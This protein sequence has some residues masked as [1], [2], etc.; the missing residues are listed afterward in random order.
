MIFI[1][2]RIDNDVVELDNHTLVGQNL[3]ALFINVTKVEEAFVISKFR[4]LHLKISY[5][6]QKAV[7]PLDADSIVSGHE[8]YLTK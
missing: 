2:A 4:A 7:F 8:D 6:V 1:D 3:E 5:Q